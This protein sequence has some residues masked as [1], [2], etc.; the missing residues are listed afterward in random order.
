M[1][2]WGKFI[3]TA[4]AC[5]CLG[6]AGCATRI[7]ETT[8]IGAPDAAGRVLIAT[9][10]TDFKTAVIERVYAAFSNDPVYFKLIDVR[11]LEKE[12]ASQYD[13]VVLLN[14]CLIWS[15]NSNVKEFVR[16]NPDNRKIFVVTT[17]G[18]DA[19]EPDITGVDAITA[20]S[21]PD[22]TDRLAEIIAL[23]I[24]AKL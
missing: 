2:I 23:R 11:N 16:D 5:I 9:Q 3:M 20:A 8:E 19:W 7:V 1:R 12:S 13:A 22:Q 24:R 18:D 17:A 6:M 21:N 10:V 15:V 14:T 4:S